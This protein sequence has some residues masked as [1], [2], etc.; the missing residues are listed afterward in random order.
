MRAAIY[1]RY[2]TDM[3]REASIEDQVR[4]CRRLIEERGWVVGDIYSDMGMS[5]ASHLRPGFQKLMEDARA[6]RFNVVV[7]ESIDRISRDQEHIAG[8]HK[9]MT[10]NGIATHTVAEGAIN[11]L[12]IGLKGTMGALFLKDLAQKTH[13]GLEGR[14]R[15]GKSA[16]GISY[17]YR[18]DRQPQPD[19]TFTTGDR[20]IDPVEAPVVRRIFEAYAEG[21]S[22]R[23][24]ARHRDS[25]QRTLPWQARVEPTAFCQRPGHWETSGPAEPARGLG[26]GSGT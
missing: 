7:A 17:G 13:R 25:E 16:G 10:F 14:V 21:E 6:G 3:Q 2:S 11:E 26:Y 9:Q 5:G 20:Q 4:I 12:H 22:A 18:L 8:F 19:G 1:A 24:I 23:T 15:A